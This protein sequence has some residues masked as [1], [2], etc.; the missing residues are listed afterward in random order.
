MDK[1]CEWEKMARHNCK[2][3]KFYQKLDILDLAK[4]II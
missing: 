4:N 2:C 3:L 1:V